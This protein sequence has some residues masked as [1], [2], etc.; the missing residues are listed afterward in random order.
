MADPTS[1]PTGDPTVKER[2]KPKVKPPPMYRVVLVND[3]FTPREFV[4]LILV[5][6]FQKD[7]GEARRIMLTA[8]QGGK[9][10]VGVYTYDVAN[11]RVE[12]A[13]RQAGEAGYPLV[14]YTEEV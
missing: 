3:D 2:V 6:V 4:I 13:R 7:R 11:S 9:S 5:S 12:R 10:V 1:T 8:H 14:L